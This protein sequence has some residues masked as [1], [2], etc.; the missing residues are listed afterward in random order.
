MGIW[1]S[2]GDIPKKNTA[3]GR[4]AKFALKSLHNDTPLGQKPLEDEC[5]SQNKQA[6]P[7][8]LCCTKITYILRRG[9]QM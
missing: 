2:L 7:T 5:I 9:C 4:C 6:L 3:K 1:A 8:I